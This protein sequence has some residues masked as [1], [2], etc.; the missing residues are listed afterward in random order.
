MNFSFKTERGNTIV[1]ACG[2]N[3]T[4]EDLLKL[5][6]KKVNLNYNLFENGKIYFLFN[7]YK[8]SIKDQRKLKEVFSH[9]GWN[10][11]II[12]GGAGFY[13]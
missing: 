8:L 1:V 2:E 11:I 7:S 10:S 6:A 13:F 9:Y 12:V 5:F 4:I 3:N